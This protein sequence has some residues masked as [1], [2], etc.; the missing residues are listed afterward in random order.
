MT[1]PHVRRR[2]SAARPT[3]LPHS[4][5]RAPTRSPRARPSC[6]ARVCSATT[7]TCP[8]SASPS[9]TSANCS[10]ATSRRAASARCSSTCAPGA[11]HDVVVCPQEDRVVSA[12]ELDLA[13]DGHVPVVLAEFALVEEVVHQDERWR[14]AMRRRGPDRPDPA[15]RQPAVGGRARR[16][17]RGRP[18]H[19]ALLHLRAEDPG[20]PRL[21]ASG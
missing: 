1:H 9:R 4:P 15:A 14:A 11:S 21:G 3:A 17:G 16:A 8:T 18:P 13:V 7:P 12:R 6:G 2:R 10:P 5:R 20:R 19:P